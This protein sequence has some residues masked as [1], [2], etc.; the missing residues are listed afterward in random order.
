[1]CRQSVY[2]IGEKAYGQAE[3]DRLVQVARAQGASAFAEQSLALADDVPAVRDEIAKVKLQT[4]VRARIARALDPDTWG[5][6]QA[7]LVSITMGELHLGALQAPAVRAQLA[8]LPGISNPLPDVE[9]LDEDDAEDAP[10]GGD[11]TVPGP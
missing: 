2:K 5:E 3:R 8:A 10:R 4:D 7:P 6:K 9:V 1:M 11:A